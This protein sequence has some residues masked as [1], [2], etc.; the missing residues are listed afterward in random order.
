MK[1]TASIRLD[2]DF[3]QIQ[4]SIS[5]TE[6]YEN[7]CNQIVPFVV[8]HR[9]WNRVAL[10]NLAYSKVRASSKLGSQMVCNAIFSVCKAYQNRQ[11]PKGEEIPTIVFRRGRSVHFDKRTYT[12][13]GEYISL[14]TLEGRITVK[15]RMSPYQQAYLNQGLPKEGELIC[16]KGKWYFNLVFDLPDPSAT[17]NTAVFAIDTGEN[18][19]AVTSSGK[20]FGGGKIRHERD[21][22]L[23]KRRRLQ[24]NGS[25]SAK[26]LMRKISGKE[27]RRVKQ[28]NHEVSK[29][30]IKEA[31]VQNAGVIVLEDLTHIR[32][33]I[34]A[35][36]KMRSRLLRWPF[37]QLQEFLAY[38]A[39]SQGLRG[40]TTF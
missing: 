1:R 39:E 3:S 13:K 14:Y 36:K 40:C 31:I 24:S 8:E 26:Q 22:Y 6:A 33:R 16:K 34:K 19:L 38:K 29:E 4:K 32:K 15:M 18:N 35:G 23:A 25:Q 12:I 28:I 27:A 7:A 21:Q 11:I 2:L 17:Q 9:C 37:R 20:F 10:H 30:I 5:L